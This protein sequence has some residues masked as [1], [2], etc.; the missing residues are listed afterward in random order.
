[1]KQYYTFHPRLIRGDGTTADEP[2]PSV[3]DMENSAVD[4]KIS[5]KKDI[6]QK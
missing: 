6:N 4:Q 2:R 1:M 3:P 5:D